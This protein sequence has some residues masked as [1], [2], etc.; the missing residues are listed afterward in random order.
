MSSSKTEGPAMS[1]T[2]ATHSAAA[3]ADIQRRKDTAAAVLEARRKRAIKALKTKQRQLGLDDATYR[4]MLQ[5]RTGKTSARD[6]T[7]QELNAVCQYLSDQGALN[8]KAARRPRKS[9]AADRAPLRGKVDQLM[10]ELGGLIT[11]RKPMDYVNA[12][13]V[14]NF[15]CSDIDMASPDML[16]GLVG[17][18]SRTIAAKTRAANKAA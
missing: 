13:L 11:I 2:H 12:I 5:T 16:R 6:C 8:P 15:G 4:V 9:I 18:L 10:I 14:K 17:A 7:E 1:R 3:C